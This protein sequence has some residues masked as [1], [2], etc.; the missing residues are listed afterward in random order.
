MI[1][2][3]V[4][5]QLALL[6][7]VALS[8]AWLSV[9]VP[10]QAFADTAFPAEA[11]FEA[12]AGTVG[13]PWQTATS[14]AVYGAYV[15][16]PSLPRQD[17]P[18]GGAELSYAV[19]IPATQSY[20]VWARVYTPND[21]ANSYFFAV[22][23]A[24]FAAWNV[25]VA[26]DWQ[27][28]K[29]GSP[30]LSEGIHELK[31]KYREPRAGIDRLV[32][33]ANL[34]YAPTGI[35]ANPGPWGIG[36]W[37]NPYPNPPVAP[38]A[39]HPRL[40]VRAA[41]LPELR[42]RLQKGLN[43]EAWTRVLADAERFSSGELPTPAAGVT[44]YNAAIRKGIEA[45]ALRYLLEQPKPAASGRKAVD[46]MLSFLNTAVFPSTIQDITRQMGQ[47]V[48]TAAIV[49][50]W[51]YELLTPQEREAFIRRMAVIAAQMEIGFPPTKQGAVVGHGGEAQLMRD[52]IGFGVAVYDEEPSVYNITA[53]RFFSQ[54]IEP[55][56]VMYASHTHHQGD[57][58]G[59]YRFQWEMYASWLFR[60]MGA[61]HVFSAEQ[62]FVPYRWMYTREPDGELVRDGDT[63][64]RTAPFEAY[65]TDPISLMLTAGYY[66]DAMINGEFQ[67]VYP[68][69]RNIDDI[70]LLLLH[71]PDLAA[72]AGD[73]LPL[74]AY[75]GAP[76]GAMTARTGWSGGAL[77][78]TV[79]ADMKI[80][81]TWFA[82][83][84]HLDAGQFQIYYK[85]GLA[86]DSGIYQ[87]VN[88][89]YGSDHD[90]NYNKR[91]I[92]HNAMLIRDP[93]ETFAYGSRTVAN[94]GGQRIPNKGAEPA[95]L[96]YMEGKGYGVA[97]VLAQQAAPG[98]A[99]DYSYLKGDLTP[100]Y[101]GKISDYKRSFVFLNLKDD[102]HPAALLVFDRVTATDA[103]YKKTW[104]L[105][106]V[107]EPDI[108]G[109]TT[110]LARTEKGY[111]GKLVSRTLLPA[112]GHANIAKL[113]GPGQE[114]VVDGVNY[115]QAYASGTDS[116]EAGNWRVEVSPS[117]PAATDS[118]LHAM[119][120][121]DHIG[122]PQPL[123]TTRIDGDGVVGAQI[124][125][126]VVLFAT[127]GASIGEH[128][129]WT[130]SGSGEQRVLVT[131]LAPGYWTVQKDGATAAVQY[132]VKAGEG[133][134]Y[135]AADAGTYTL[136][137][138]A[139]RT[140][141]EPS[142][143]ASLPQPAGTDRIE[144]LL[145][146]TALGFPQGAPRLTGGAV[147]APYG[148]LLSALG[149]ESVLADGV[150][151]AEMN[152]TT[153]TLT[154]GS[155]QA[156]VNGQTVTLSAPV[157]TVSG[158]VYIPLDA[159][160]KAAWV[161]YAYD[162][163]FQRATLKRRTFQPAAGIAAVTASVYAS[164][165]SSTIDGS[166]STGWSA[167][168]D[169]P[170]IQYTLSDLQPMNRI[171]LAWLQGADR[172]YRYRVELSADGT[173]WQTVYD[174][175]SGGVAGLEDVYFP[176][177]SAKYVRIVGSGFA[178][179]GGGG[180]LTAL[181]E[182]KLYPLKLSVAGVL[183]TSD[184]GNVGANTL[185]GDLNT[186]WSAEGYGEWIRY[187]LGA[188]QTLTGLTM[189]FHKGNERRTSFAVLTSLD[190]EQWTELYAGQSSGATTEPEPVPIAAGAARY[191]K[192]VGYGNSTG[193]MWNSITEAGLYGFP[194]A[195]QT[196]LRTLEATRDGS[197]VTVSGSV[198]GGAGK[199][200]EVAV[201]NAAGT[202]LHSAAAVSD[203]DGAFASSFAPGGASGLLI[204][205]ASGP[206]IRNPQ[207]RAL[208]LP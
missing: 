121:M 110:T 33:T 1:S 147:T 162:A 114:F 19:A 133:T 40:F 134:L 17:P 98:Y 10:R 69:K 12:E 64:Q 126:R 190:G 113:G 127:D 52:L 157:A 95:T 21:G 22:D 80:G 165:A 160:S 108:S 128:A 68:G 188:V 156:T 202:P 199:T 91:T 124:G 194:D 9:F 63:T 79:V 89:G 123:A 203:A 205:K 41:D 73:S 81:G 30:T 167:S 70:W 96:A 13:T 4:R 201:Y 84:Q 74:T 181:A 144:V 111:N 117:A 175:Q 101:S 18:V 130:L 75:F 51:C 43:Q 45:N 206:D 14:A 20:N 67:R 195:R 100:A 78:K 58:Y 7:T 104:L 187:D 28:V 186:R 106:S 85:G 197:A 180:S 82:N 155:D 143:L 170:W 142:P 55:R 115:P 37:P 198:Y 5:R 179:A 141:P 168:G 90:Y 163:F 11:I 119:Q 192:I 200:V 48:F 2:R 38:P 32:V 159:L 49:Y 118:F 87:G 71:D 138:A 36:P 23:N 153:L 53:G 105:H 131:D 88:G 107:E 94:D 129:S 120:V 66:G 135:F 189:A 178:A 140:L 125:D 54:F 50:D 103:T 86:I 44:N 34:Q 169:S 207:T 204:V 39:E 151:T 161:T 116:G 47:T 112:A 83:H 76:Y 148:P 177:A 60:R 61:G 185:D 193:S 35:G 99:P 72:Q 173:G 149:A 171:G 15:T 145:D 184:D 26:A 122:G 46:M 166:L 172:Y 174:G 152:G 191:V 136:T 56:N 62:Q 16:T 196:L 57:S 24:S 176:Q 77:S 150:L 8:A 93:N 97:Q 109:D 29:V 102:D 27:W 182:F 132:E 31:F 137:H 164:Q 65:W 183:T 139:A 146:Q 59:P 158:V 25:T 208:E 154:S 3:Y 6:L 92:A 42:A